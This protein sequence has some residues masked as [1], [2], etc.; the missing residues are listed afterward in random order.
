[1]PRSHLAATSI[2]LEGARG[3]YAA[4]FTS[5][6]AFSTMKNCLTSFT[7][8]RLPS[9]CSGLNPPP[10]AKMRSFFLLLLLSWASSIHVDLRSPPLASKIPSGG[11]CNKRML[12]SS[13]SHCTVLCLEPYVCWEPARACVC[14]CL[15]DASFSPSSTRCSGCG[16]LTKSESPEE[17]VC[18]SAFV[19]TPS[20]TGAAAHTAAAL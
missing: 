20:L 11:V 19:S 8:A 15:I 16:G 17:C 7:S 18:V 4:A 9:S 10:A 12:F 6:S 1:M 13:A 5:T 3:K 2:F 14:V